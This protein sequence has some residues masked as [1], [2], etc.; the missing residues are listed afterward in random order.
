MREAFG[1]VFMIRL[2]LVFVFIFV[3]FT[4]IS[5]NYAKAFRIK[6]KVIDFVEQQEAFNLDALFSG[7]DGK[8]LAKLDKILDDAKYN[9]EC[10][11]TGGNGKIPTA[12][13][14][15]AAYCYRGIIVEENEIIDNRTIKYNVYTYADW[16]LGTLNMIFALGG[17]NSNS[18]YVINGVWEISGTATVV[19]RK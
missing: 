13:G 1:G 15:P 18:G 9:K 14:A 3:A 16:N 4:A 11:N 8:N 12:A 6:N 2:M 19:K 17:R 7:G 10:Q 5:L